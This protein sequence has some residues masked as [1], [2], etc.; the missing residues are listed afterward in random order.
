MRYN[1]PEIL[2]AGEA[3]SFIQEIDSTSSCSYKY[4][5]IFYDA[6]TIPVPCTQ[7]AYQADE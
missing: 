5:D 2:K 6:A 4:S 3:A 7:C 1:K